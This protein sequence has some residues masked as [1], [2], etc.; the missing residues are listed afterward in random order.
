MEEDE[1]ESGDLTDEDFEALLASDG[2]IEENPGEEMEDEAKNV[3]KQTLGKRKRGF[4]EGEEDEEEYEKEQLVYEEMVGKK[5]KK[6][7]IIAKVSHFVFIQRFWNELKEAI[8]EKLQELA[9]KLPDGKIPPWIETLVLSTKV[10]TVLEDP[11]DDLER[12][13]ALYSFIFWDRHH[14][15]WDI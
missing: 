13:T 4:D 2:E 12:E 9:L 11:N 7:D 8:E 6:E 3:T 10:E 5:R 1:L 14:F 15:N